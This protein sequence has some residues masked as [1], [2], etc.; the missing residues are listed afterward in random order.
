MSKSTTSAVLPAVANAFFAVAGAY[1]LSLTGFWLL[2]VTVGESLN[3]VA[4]INNLLHLMLLPS[5]L[6]LPIALVARRWIVSATLLLPVTVTALAYAPLLD[7]PPPPSD[8]GR[9]LTVFTNNIMAR[10]GGF[11]GTIDIIQAADADI[12]TLQ[13][14]W[15][16]ARDAL[17]PALADDYPYL[18]THVG[19][20]PVQGQALF[21]RYPIL[22]DEYF[23]SQLPVR[24]GHQRTLID[25]DGT[26]IAIYNVHLLHPGVTQLDVSVR[27][28]DVTSV[29]SRAAAETAPTL[30]MGDFNM[31][32][33][34]ADY[35]DISATYTD[36]FRVA[37][38]GLGYSF[39]HNGG[40]PPL[41]RIDYIFHDDTWTVNTVRL[42]DHSTGA[43]HL[44]LY[45]ELALM[46]E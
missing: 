27:S 32:P 14:Y 45:A 6:L 15:G 39:P 22:E 33:F 42:W 38:R 19:N 25:M 7:A 23:Q 29:L 43:D 4:L 37:G 21:S 46:D 2:R 1:G 36:A 13:E 40:L 5:V 9:P 11:D 8:A 44:P 24:F 16:P 12:V 10:T 17:E 18:A 34:T 30:I 31:T 28:Q 26:P 20:S 35:A 41:A 3:M